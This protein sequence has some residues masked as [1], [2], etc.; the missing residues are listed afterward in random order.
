MLYSRDVSTGLKAFVTVSIVIVNM[1]YV[2]AIGVEVV[3]GEF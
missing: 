3:I 1:L 2:G